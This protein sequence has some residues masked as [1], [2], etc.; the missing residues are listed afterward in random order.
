M[1]G[2]F[3]KSQCQDTRLCFA[4]GDFG[5][6]Y[7]LTDPYKHDRECPFC[8]PNRAWTKGKYY[9]VDKRYGSV[10]KPVAV[11][12]LEEEGSDEDVLSGVNGMVFR[13]HRVRR[14]VDL[15]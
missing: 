3:S 5:G 11:S 2:Q 8:K 14:S 7:I 1:T 10:K 13:R 6:C 4:R 12:E 9:P 15:Y